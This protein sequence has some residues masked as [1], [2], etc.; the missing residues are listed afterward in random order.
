M[1]TGKS[2]KL[3]QVLLM[4]IFL[5][6]CAK[7]AHLDQLLTIK[8]YSDNKDLQEKFILQQ[9]QNFKKLLAAVKDGTL[10]PG[11]THRVILKEFGAPIL[12]R[13]T[14]AD[15]KDLDVWL[16]RYATEYF[17]SEKVYLYF[18][19]EGK[20]VKWDLVTPSPKEKSSGETQNKES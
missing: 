20:L 19:Q 16:Y 7:V 1:F 4:V 18:D 5:S 15:G 12:S 6:G 11:T 8:A 2:C 3:F 17:N 9:N 14:A 10:E 13:L